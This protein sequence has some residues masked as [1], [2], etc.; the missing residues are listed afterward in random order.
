MATLGAKD[1][2]PP[3]P[4]GQQAALG[5]FAIPEKGVFALGHA[6]FD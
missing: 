3:A 2:G 1:L 6:F 4:L 5:E